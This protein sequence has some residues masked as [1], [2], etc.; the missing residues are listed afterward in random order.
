M[1]FRL[2]EDLPV[3]LAEWRSPDTMTATVTG[4]IDIAGSIA[5][6]CLDTWIAMTSL[7]G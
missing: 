5:D 3:E 4:R 7:T 6:A 1:R 2:D